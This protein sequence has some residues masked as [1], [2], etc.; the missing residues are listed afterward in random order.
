MILQERQYNEL[1]QYR[2]GLLNLREKAADRPIAVGGQ[3]F[4]PT[5]GAFIPVPGQER[6]GKV[7]VRRLPDG[8]SV[9]VERDDVTGKETRLEGYD[10]FQTYKG[11]GL[12]DVTG[13]IAKLGLTRVAYPVYD[14]DGTQI[15]LY[16]TPDRAA[17]VA[18]RRK[19]RTTGPA[20]EGE[21]K[22]HKLMGDMTGEV[23][24]ATKDTLDFL[25]LLRKQQTNLKNPKTFTFKESKKFPAN[26]PKTWA[27]LKEMMQSASSR[28]EKK[29]LYDKYSDLIEEP[30]QP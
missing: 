9:Y 16:N 8:T 6:A 25:S 3:L 5:T 27:E 11:E 29:R 10:P 28:E 1:S 2:Q 26:A 24:P 7:Y 19:G 21:F 18:K 13:K 20:I 17:A 15:G 12:A 22:L 23:E 30:W 14:R 4:D